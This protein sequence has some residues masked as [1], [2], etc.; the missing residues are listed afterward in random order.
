M[1]DLFYG[2]VRKDDLLSDIFEGTIKDNWTIH[3]EKMYCFWQTILLAQHIYRGSPF[4]PHATL[5]V[6]KKHF[7]RWKQLFI[8]TVDENFMGGRAEEAKFRTKKM[9]EMFQLKIEY[10]QK[11]T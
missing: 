5:P 8:E 7:E 4:A 9:A 10:F 6:Q 2:K 1:V 3:L 11:N